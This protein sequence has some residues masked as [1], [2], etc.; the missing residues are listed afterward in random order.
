M[1]SALPLGAAL[2]QGALVTLANWPIVILEFGIEAVYKLA[3]GVPIVG[4][5]LMVATLLDADFGSLLGELF[6]AVDQDPL[7]LSQKIG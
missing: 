4:G 5:A 2:R 7:R 6:G 3:L 1:T